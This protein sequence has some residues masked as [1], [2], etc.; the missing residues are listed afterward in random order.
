MLSTEERG[1]G[2]P[3]AFRFGAA[4]ALTFL[5]VPM[6]VIVLAA[7][8]GGSYLTFPPE[9]LSLRWVLAFLGLGPGS[10]VASTG[11]AGATTVFIRAFGYSFLLA[12]LSTLC[13]LL[14]GTMTALV[15]TRYD[16]PGRSF[17]Q[18]FFLSPIMLP[19][20]VIGLALFVYYRVLFIGLSRSLLGLL[21]G[22]VIVTTPFVVRTVSAS[23]YNFDL[24]LEEAARNLGASPLQTFRRITLPLISP[25]M[26]AGSIFAFIVS[27]GQFDVTIFLAT[28]ENQTLPLAIFDHLRFHS[29]PTAAAAGVFSI[30]LV[31]IS[32]LITARTADLKTFAGFGGS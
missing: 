27:F 24:S 32:L 30:T 28:P 7:L 14:L 21:I 3:Y 16:F 23:L 15:L 12:T 17:L 6:I 5:L 1:L 8:T 19:G 31:I 26:M 4:V 2:M 18:A 20:I 29:D 11:E 22:H 13:A 25:G 10:Y 9:G